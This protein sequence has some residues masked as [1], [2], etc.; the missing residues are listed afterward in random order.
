M[1]L[2]VVVA[3]AAGTGGLGFGL[4]FL[5]PVLVQPVLVWRVRAQRKHAAGMK[6]SEWGGGCATAHFAGSLGQANG[7]GDKRAWWVEVGWGEVPSPLDD[8]PSLS[9]DS[10]SSLRFFSRSMRR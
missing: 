4:A 1:Y 6:V 5:V 10:F 7:Q 3:F 8:P 9:L 2:V